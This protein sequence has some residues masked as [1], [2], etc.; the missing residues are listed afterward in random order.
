MVDR[1]DRLVG[2]YVLCVRVV[3]M[4]VYE[5]DRDRERERRREGQRQ[6]DRDRQRQTETGR[7]AAG[8]LRLRQ[9]DTWKE[10]DRKSASQPASQTGRQT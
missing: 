5:R 4:S 7:Q 9:A 3:V 8:K 10:T 1:Y 2:I 6:R